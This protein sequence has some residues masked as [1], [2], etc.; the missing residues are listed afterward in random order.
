M[1]SAFRRNP[2]VPSP[3]K[4]DRRWE[5]DPR[6][7]PPSPRT[8]ITR[9]DLPWPVRAQFD[10]M[11]G[12]LVKVEDAARGLLVAVSELRTAIGRELVANLRAELH[13]DIPKPPKAR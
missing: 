2:V 4:P 3:P 11:D 8:T 6:I 7:P 9:D 1:P 12:A 10:S 13:A 5:E